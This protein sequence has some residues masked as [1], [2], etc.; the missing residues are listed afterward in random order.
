MGNLKISDGKNEL[1][2]LIL[3]EKPSKII[4]GLRYAGGKTYPAM[5]SKFA[6]C[7][8]AHTV[9]IL[10]ILEKYQIIKFEKD[11]RIKNVI[12]TEKG[13]EIGF[14]LEQIHRKLVKIHNDL[15]E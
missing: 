11:G 8:Y 3:H 6:D 10:D 2:N 14:L 13:E 12:L 9:K 5:L 1:V 15:R 7:T 4:L